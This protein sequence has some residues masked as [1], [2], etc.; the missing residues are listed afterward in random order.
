MIDSSVHG[1]STKPW[2]E[3]ITVVKRINLGKHFIKTVVK[4]FSG[5]FFTIR[6]HKRDVHHIPVVLFVQFLL[7]NTVVFFATLNQELQVFV[8]RLLSNFFHVQYGVVVNYP[9]SYIKTTAKVA[10]NKKKRLK[11]D[12][13]S[14]IHGF[15]GDVIHGVVGG[16][17]GVF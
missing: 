17:T 4:D 11:T 13:F 2:L 15:E 9:N 10:W 1:N 16:I 8:I 5:F 7:T 14:K 3:R 6:I 12:I